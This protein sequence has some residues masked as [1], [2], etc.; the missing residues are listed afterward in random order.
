MFHFFRGKKTE[1]FVSHF[2]L[3]F[4]SDCE[5]K[6]IP[7]RTLKINGRSLCVMHRLT[8]RISYRTIFFFIFETN[9]PE[10][11]LQNDQIQVLSL[12]LFD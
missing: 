2:P 10:S 6:K 4:Q 7:K 5:E 3:M 11:S 1:K 12:R 9:Q 8:Y